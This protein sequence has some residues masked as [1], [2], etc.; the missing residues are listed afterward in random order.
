MAN[1]K[2]EEQIE[3]VVEPTEQKKSKGIFRGN[4]NII[5]G[6]NR[7]SHSGAFLF[8]NPSNEHV[9]EGQLHKM[10]LK[11][12]AIADKEKSLD[13]KIAHVDKTLLEI[14]AIAKE[15]KGK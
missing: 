12:K 10:S 5:T 11:E 6:W 3:E 4:Q 15:I 9:V 7:C 8:S 14:K 1:K 13:E 2:T